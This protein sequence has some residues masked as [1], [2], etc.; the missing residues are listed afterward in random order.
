[1]ERLHRASNSAAQH[2]SD[3][4]LSSAA[5]PASTKQPAASLE[6]SS[7][8]APPASKRSK[9]SA[10][11]SGGASGSAAR[12]APLL[13]QVEQLEK[14]TEGKNETCLAEPASMRAKT[15]SSNGLQGD[16]EDAGITAAYIVCPAD[17][18]NFNIDRN[19]KS[20]IQTVRNAI[21]AGADIVNISFS[22]TRASQ[23]ASHIGA[24]A[25]PALK[26]VFEAEWISSVEQPAYSCRTVGSVM[27]F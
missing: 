1:M 8:A 25:L 5:Q 13:E 26:L 21:E 16:R 6:A 10:N 20:L 23:D 27:S 2:A 19:L 11:H 3:E 18:Q 22:R 4:G 15:A 9:L 12:P 14:E 7:S 17:A 24:D